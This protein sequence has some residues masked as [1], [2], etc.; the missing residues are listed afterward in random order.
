M[1]ENATYEQIRSYCLGYLSDTLDVPKNEEDIENELL[2]QNLGIYP[3][4]VKPGVEFDE[5]ALPLNTIDLLVNCICVDLI[6]E[7]I[8]KNV[9]LGNGGTL[10]E[11][12]YNTFNT[13][14][15]GVFTSLEE[16]SES[17]VCR[18]FLR[19]QFARGKN[20][21]DVYHSEMRERLFPNFCLDKF[22]DV[23]RFVLKELVSDDGELY[24]ALEP[25]E[26]YGHLFPTDKGSCAYI[27]EY[28]VE[29]AMSYVMKPDIYNYDEMLYGMLEARVNLGK[30]VV[31]GDKEFTVHTVDEDGCYQFVVESS[32]CVYH[33]LYK[34]NCKDD[35]KE[36]VEIS[37][38]YSEKGY[39][40]A[41]KVN[42]YSTK[43]GRLEISPC[44][45]FSE[46]TVEEIC[47]IDNNDSAL[48]AIYKLNEL[49]SE[50]MLSAGCVVNIRCSRPLF[51][52]LNNNYKYNFKFWDFASCIFEFNHISSPNGYGFENKTIRCTTR[53]EHF[54]EFMKHVERMI[55][56]E[57]VVFPST[58][59][60]VVSY[61]SKNCIC[62]PIQSFGFG[63]RCMMVSGYIM[64]L[65]FKRKERVHNHQSE[66]YEQ[67]KFILDNE[68]IYPYFKE[69][70]KKTIFYKDKGYSGMKYVLDNE[71][72]EISLV[73]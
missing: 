46:Q 7:D 48:K 20:Y 4:D 30:R 24:C 71:T 14:F 41:L 62:E 15:P 45:L 66:T 50:V 44:Y 59:E 31:V 49:A 37:L 33:V 38:P 60:A 9:F 3:E 13:R 21:L 19:N 1:F 56:E 18:H 10:I 26:E 32:G 29:N 69:E 55:Y 5:D 8:F 63:L 54:S 28:D 73:F 58:N 25:S 51:Y 65:F 43:S 52:V 53:D 6:T 17:M 11:C 57:N 39:K 36:Y 47:D 70:G 35:D 27:M 42:H 64:D 23:D 68:N 40:L 61:I 72:Q 16:F 12:F 34:N 22:F 2:D 67:R